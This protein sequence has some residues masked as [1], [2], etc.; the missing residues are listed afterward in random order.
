MEIIELLTPA[1]ESAW[2]PWA[3]SYFFL[4]GIAV[5]A[6]LLASIYAFAKNKEAEQRLLPTF[7]LVLAMAA[8]TA[9]VALLADLQQPARFWHFYA[10]FTP[11]SW[12]SLGALLLPTF[13]GLSVVMCAL[14]WLGQARWMRWLAP[15]LIVSALSISLYTGMEIMVIRARPLWNTIWVPI[16]LMLT[17]WLATVGWSFILYRI[18]PKRLQPSTHG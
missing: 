6:A 11:W 17:G 4:I 8:I 9:P 3:V 5:G 13:V 7:I 1:Y 14:W 12:M 2:L 16:N 10:H 15:L 18:L